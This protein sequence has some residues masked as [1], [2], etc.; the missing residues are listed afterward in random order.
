[1]AIR[2]AHLHTCSWLRPLRVR[3][4]FKFLDLLHKQVTSGFRVLQTVLQSL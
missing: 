2:S 4:S 1:M 3:Q